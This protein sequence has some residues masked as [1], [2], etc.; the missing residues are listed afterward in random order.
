MTIAIIF[1]QK[2]TPIGAN[3]VFSPKQSLSANNEA[4]YTP[5]FDQPVVHARADCTMPGPA[6][7]AGN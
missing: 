2:S 5:D 3:A 4:F 7:P 6:G 1:R